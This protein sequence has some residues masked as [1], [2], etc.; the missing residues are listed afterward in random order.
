MPKHSK[1]RLYLRASEHAAAGGHRAST[2]YHSGTSISSTNLSRPLP[3]N[4][5]ALSLSPFT[6]PMFA[7]TCG[8]IFDESSILP[9]LKEH[10]ACPITGQ[11][12]NHKALVPLQMSKDTSTNV[13]Q[14]PVLN[15]PFT[16]N[17][18]VV[19]IKTSKQVYSHE[20]VSELCIKGK[21]MYDLMTGEKF[22]KS[23]IVVLQD[24]NDAEICSRRD[25]SSLK[26][27][28]QM[29][30]KNAANSINTSHNASM[31]RVMDAVRENAAQSSQRSASS[32]L[33]ATAA[34]GSHFYADL[35]GLLTS[36]LPNL[37]SLTSGATASSLT[38]TASA[39]SSKSTTRAA[40][41]DEIDDAVCWMLRKKKKKK[42]FANLVTSLGSI[43]LELDS[44]ITP[45]T[46]MN[47]TRLIQS[48]FYDNSIFHRVI[49]GFMAQGGDP[50]GTGT[51]G[52]SCWGHPFP[53]EFDARLT[54][55]ERGTLSMANAGP[56]TN[57]S[58]FFITF[59]ATPHLDNKHTLFGRVVGGMDVLDKIERVSIGK[60]D[61]PKE[62]LKI[63]RATMVVDL[64]GEAVKELWA[65]KAETE[66]GQKEETDRKER[67][68]ASK[69]RER[70]EG[71]TEEKY[72]IGKFLTNNV[73]EVNEPGDDFIAPKKKK[74]GKTG[75]GD[76][77]GW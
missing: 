30:A 61:K 29:T 52:Q 42:S 23:D 57:K 32:P 35:P 76:F 75:F 47:F 55:N 20:A 33:E 64:V 39:I 37:A 56:G 63:I 53:D 70:E 43:Q 9:Y 27:T 44:D 66:K 46:V 26:G 36:D 50:T 3:F 51:G 48:G 41:P 8:L 31:R 69:K 25:I 71:S 16:N 60:R 62:D 11:T 58:Q 1:D 54:H 7:H 45:K 19:F 74:K 77:G 14:C 72:V 68:I 17:T 10:G 34:A 38:S 2:K 22:K 65:R 28:S 21:N 59:K 13:W 15:K 12:L 40:N 5:C 18:K 73:E 4:A 67:L 49:P 24:P 6:S